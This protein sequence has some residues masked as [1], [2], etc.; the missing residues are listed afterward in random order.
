MFET[1]FLKPALKNI[2]G[3]C[4]PL[5][6]MSKYRRD[7]G[8]LQMTFHLWLLA[9]VRSSCVMIDCKNNINKTMVYEP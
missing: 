9:A 1:F 6:R 5:S 4:T 7:L 8:A 3:F 2:S